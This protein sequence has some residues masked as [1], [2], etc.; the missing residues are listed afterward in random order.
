MQSLDGFDADDAF[1]LGLVRQERRAGNI[2]DGVN[3]GHVGLA[4]AIG[5]DRAALGLHAELF[6]PEI[7]DIADNPYRGNDPLNGE[8]QRAALAVVDS[9]GDAVGLLIELRHFGAG[10]NFDA[11]LLK[12][13]ARE[14]GDLGVLDGKNLRQH[15][16]HGHLS[17]ERPVERS[18]FDADGARADDQ[19]RFRHAVRHHGLEVGPDQF[20]V[21]FQAR[22]NARAGAGGEDYVLGLVRAGS[23]RALRRFYFCPASP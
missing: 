18:E 1:V 5:D 12:T 8:R 14:G 4:G 2:A 6:Q 20:L 17:A 7:L 10:V 13:L 16:D 15:F 23:E 21:R 11:L 9:C 19:Q 3:A 22:Q